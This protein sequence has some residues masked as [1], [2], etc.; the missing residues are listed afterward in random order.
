[1]LERNHYLT[2]GVQT[3]ESVAGIRHAFCEHLKRYHPD[4]LGPSRASYFYAIVEAYRTLS[5]PERRR[6][7][8]RGLLPA[9]FSAAQPVVAGPEG[10][11]GLPQICSSLRSSRIVDA[12]FEAAL[13]QAS[14]NLTLARFDEQKFSQP[15]NGDV[16]LS[17]EEAL[18][19]GMLDI[20]VP[21]CAPCL[22]CGGAGRQGLFPCELCDGEGLREEEENLRVPVPPNVSDGTRITVPLRG[23]GLHNF[24]FSVRIRV[25][26]SRGW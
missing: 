10:V 16:I 19:G 3:N 25:H 23:L 18:R 2:L 15:L 14:R 9:K 21:G 24:Y 8:D 12:F 20:A 1:M 26:G 22:R 6:D 11:G 13:G 5:H 7:Y 17:P 4:L